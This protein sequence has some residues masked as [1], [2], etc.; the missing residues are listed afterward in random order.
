MAPV[1]TELRRHWHLHGTSSSHILAQIAFN[2]DYPQISIAQCITGI[3][4][5]VKCLQTG[6]F[7]E[8]A[9]HVRVT[10]PVNQFCLAVFYSVYLRQLDLAQLHYCR[11]Y[12]DCIRNDFLSTLPEHHT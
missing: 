3:I 1:E 6:N 11:R 9:A 8:I 2:Y 12:P 4:T 7:A 5:G 10:E